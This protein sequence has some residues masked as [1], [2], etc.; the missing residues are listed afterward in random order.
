MASKRASILFQHSS[1]ASR[2]SAKRVC[3]AL[4]FAAS[5]LASFFSLRFSYLSFQNNDVSVPNPNKL[6]IDIIMGTQISGFSIQEPVVSVNTVNNPNILNLL[7]VARSFTDLLL[8]Y[9]NIIKELRDI[10]SNG[11]G[12]FRIEDIRL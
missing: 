1:V 9:I 6:S 11:I 12:N 8:S 7:K 5:V 10:K 4:A 2:I 3:F